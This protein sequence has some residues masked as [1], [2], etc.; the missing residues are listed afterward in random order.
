MP[1]EKL[2]WSEE[3]YNRPDCRCAELD[4]HTFCPVHGIDPS[5]NKWRT[6]S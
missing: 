2:E 5:T 1:D 4:N 6:P 3:S